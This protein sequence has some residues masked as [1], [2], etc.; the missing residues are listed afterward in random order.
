L[1]AQ[2]EHT[3]CKQY[4]WTIVIMMRFQ[5]GVRDA[6]R[7]GSP[8][9]E[10]ALLA[11]IAQHDRA[12]LQQL[13]LGYHRRLSRFLMR[14]VHRYDVAEE[15]INDT[16]LV[17]WQ[18]AGKFRGDSQVST[19]I[20]GIAYRRALKELKRLGRAGPPLVPT[21]QP[22]RS[23]DGPDDAEATR[24]EVRECIDQALA[25]L[26]SEQRLAVELCYFMGH[27]CEEIAE[28]AGCPVNTVKTRMFHARLRLRALLPDLIPASFAPTGADSGRAGQ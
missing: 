26:P 4:A 17:V 14:V 1:L 10:R 6:S 20:I 25:E 7:K 8:D 9:D 23:V 22:E 3:V 5:A 28:I 21:V 12:A 13:Y 15:V 24:R 18:Q 11:R 16:M 2:R 19:W 27:S